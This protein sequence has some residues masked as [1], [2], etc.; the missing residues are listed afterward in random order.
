MEKICTKCEVSKSIDEFYKRYSSCKGCVKIKTNKNKEN[1]KEYKKKYYQENKEKIKEKLDNL[2]L[3]KKEKLKESGRLSYERNKEKYKEKSREN[4]RKYHK[5]KMENDIIYRL[6]IGFTRRINKSIKRNNFV[7]SN[8]IPLK[9][10]IGCSF[11]E[12][13]L[14]LESKFESWM[15]WDN[16]GLYNGE[17]NYGWDIDHKIPISSVKTEEGVIELNHYTNLQPLCSRTNR[18]IKRNNF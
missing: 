3:D 15:N 7:N 1:S 6:K 16:Y 17:L 2:P 4:R 9:E 12:F 11:G 13:K 10:S 8:S 18:D 14:Y 5:F